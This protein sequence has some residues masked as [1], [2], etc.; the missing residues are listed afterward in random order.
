MRTSPPSYRGRRTRE[1]ETCRPNGSRRSSS[2]VGQAGLATGYHLARKGQSFAILDASERVGDSWRR[3]WPSLRLYTPA[4][5]DGLPGM[6]FPAPRY[7]YPTAIEMADYLESYATRFDLPV[8]NGV[9]VDALERNDEG[10]VVTAGTRRFE[11]DNVVVAT[12][13]MQH[14][15]PVVPEFAGELDPSIRALALRRLPRPRAVAG[16][17][18]ARRRAPRTREATSPTRSR[19]PA[20]RRSLSGPDTGRLPSTSRAAACA[21]RCRC[22]AS[23]RP[24]C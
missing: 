19:K 6:P 10:Y 3:R 13:V 23:W 1:E 24:A 7:S 18:G 9:V 21:L 11:A 12:G 4:A 14:E 20:S 16:R 22:C 2:G 5:L 15:S 17:R 8:R